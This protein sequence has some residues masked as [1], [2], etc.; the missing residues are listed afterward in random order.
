MRSQNHFEHK[1]E[2]YGQ[3]IC[4]LAFNS[5]DYMLASGSNDNSVMVYDISKQSTVHRFEEHKAAVKALAWSP[6]QNG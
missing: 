2:S 5:F 1:I 6:H 4:G 3:E